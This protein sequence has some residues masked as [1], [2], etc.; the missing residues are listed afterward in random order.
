MRTRLTERPIAFRPEIEGTMH[1]YR[2]VCAKCG[3]QMGLARIELIDQPD[4][5]LRTFEC[6]R[7]STELTRTMRF[8]YSKEPP[9][10]G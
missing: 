6:I 4:H 10:A 5:D 1:G 9:R 3:V 2:P 7:C 8:M